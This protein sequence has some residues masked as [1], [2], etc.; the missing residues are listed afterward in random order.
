MQLIIIPTLTFCDENEREPPA[1]AVLNDLH[2]STKFYC[3]FNNSTAISKTEQI[4]LSNISTNEFERLFNYLNEL[5]SQSLMIS[6][7]LRNESENCAS[8]VDDLK[9]KIEENIQRINIKYNR[10][11]DIDEDQ[12]I[13]NGMEESNVQDLLDESEVII[14]KLSEL[15]ANA[16][17]LKSLA[18]R[19]S[20]IE[21]AN[22]TVIWAEKMNNKLKSIISICRDR[23]IVEI[24]KNEPVNSNNTMIIIDQIDSSSESTF[25]AT[26][27]H[28]SLKILTLT[29]VVLTA[30]SVSRTNLFTTLLKSF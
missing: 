17:Q 6:L 4:R 21:Y 20:I 18:I 14:E 29:F 1:I 26:D 12:L 8:R 3:K 13:V 16:E 5:K 19:Y 24:D 22:E 25:T 10:L 2:I 27:K 15:N 7:Q 9:E 23:L 11:F 30:I 28:R